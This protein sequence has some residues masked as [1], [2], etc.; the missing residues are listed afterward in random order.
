ML[1]TSSWKNARAGRPHLPAQGRSR[2]RSPTTPDGKCGGSRSSCMSSECTTRE[3]RRSTQHM[4][5]SQSDPVMLGLSRQKYWNRRSDLGNDSLWRDS[6]LTEGP[7][8]SS[9]PG[10]DVKP[11]QGPPVRRGPR[12]SACKTYRGRTLESRV[13][14]LFRLGSTRVAAKGKAQPLCL[15]DRWVR[16]M[17]GW[18]SPVGG[19]PRCSKAQAFST[20][21]C[22]KRRGATASLAPSPPTAATPNCSSL[23]GPSTDSGSPLLVNARPQRVRRDAREAGCR[24]WH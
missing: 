23:Q 2:L 1:L 24:A 18:S 5:R 15:P 19:T 20:S 9:C 3:S 16:P 12:K 22:T 10:L 17:H 13:G 21:S 4:H 8:R 7:C 6:R 14:C 11:P